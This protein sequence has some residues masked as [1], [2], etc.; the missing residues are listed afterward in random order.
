[1][2][3]WKLSSVHISLYLIVIITCGHIKYPTHS[4]H[5]SQT[6]AD[7]QRTES[8]GAGNV[9]TC[10][11]L[12][13]SIQL[14]SQSAQER[15]P[16]QRDN[17]H[18]HT[19]THTHTLTHIHKHSTQTHGGSKQNMVRFPRVQT[20][21]AC[22]WK[23]SLRTRVHDTIYLFTHTSQPHGIDV[24]LCSRAPMCRMKISTVASWRCLDTMPC[25]ACRHRGAWPCMS[26]P[27]VG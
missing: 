15:A 2:A 10:A 7:E 22:N 1:M 26:T 11:R 4:P 14:F 8:T 21:C 16:R 6:Q 5:Y 17:K 18:R 20:W 24:C 25:A 9:H 27:V 23:L 13:T 3:Q 19:C 12:R